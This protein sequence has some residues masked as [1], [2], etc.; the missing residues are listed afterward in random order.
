MGTTE[1]ECWL[2]GSLCSPEHR[3]LFSKRVQDD[4]PHTQRAA[5]LRT[6]PQ[7]PLLRVE[8]LWS[9]ADCSLL[10]RSVGRLPPLCPPKSVLSLAHFTW[11]IHKWRQSLPHF[12]TRAERLTKCK[13]AR[14]EGTHDSKLHW[15]W[16]RAENRPGVVGAHHERQEN[17]W[18]A[19]PLWKWA[20][21]RERL[22]AVGSCWIKKPLP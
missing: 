15:V 6:A 1:A 7:T 13:Q 10:K 5:N 17:W 12:R 19:A 14:R 2:W 4:P 11:R 8:I 16:I 20:Q 18:G 9:G 22:E 3:T 21:E